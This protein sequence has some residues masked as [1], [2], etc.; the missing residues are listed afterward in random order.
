MLAQSSG[1]E[2]RH[3]ETG[4][5]S[6][7]LSL[8]PTL[9]RTLTLALNLCR[10]LSLPWVGGTTT[11]YHPHS[12]VP[13]CFTGGRRRHLKTCMAACQ[14]SAPAKVNSSELY[15]M[16]L[17]SSPW[18]CTSPKNFGGPSPLSAQEVKRGLQR[19]HLVRAP[20]PCTCSSSP[21]WGLGSRIISLIRGY[22]QPLTSNF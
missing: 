20:G 15:R 2:A 21:S 7:T 6:L 8:S 11:V 12:Q 1:G 19:P 4:V 13:V 10:V 16:R 5:R 22:G 9:T 18:A 14:S 17:P 3:L